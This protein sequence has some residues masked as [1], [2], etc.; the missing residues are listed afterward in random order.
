MPLAFGFFRMELHIGGKFYV[1]DE[2]SGPFQET[3]VRKVGG[4]VGILLFRAPCDRKHR[5]V[6]TAAVA[7]FEQKEMESS[8]GRRT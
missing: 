3:E 4:P 1:V 8:W 6:V 5:T 7:G 2:V